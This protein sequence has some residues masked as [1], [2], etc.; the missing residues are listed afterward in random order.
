M[1]SLWRAERT[2]R[3]LGQHSRARINAPPLSSTVPAV[4][5]LPAVC[6]GGVEVWRFDT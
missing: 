6:R 2:A 5:M 4:G 1:S 3:L